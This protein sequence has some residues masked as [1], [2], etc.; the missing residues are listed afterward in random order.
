M[1]HIGNGVPA[2]LRAD[3]PTL[4]EDFTSVTLLQAVESLINSATK[5]RGP[6][7]IVPGLFASIQI[8]ASPCATSVNFEKLFLE[9][10]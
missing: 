7:R 1:L 9:C 10:R 2:T 5:L 6:G 8:T 3:V 4:D